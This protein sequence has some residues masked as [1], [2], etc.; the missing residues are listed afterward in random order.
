M[1]LNAP[2]RTHDF[3]SEYLQSPPTPGHSTLGYAPCATKKTLLFSLAFTERP[4]FLPTFTQWP[5]IFNKLL[6]TERPWHI[7]VTQRPLIFAFNDKFD[8]MLRN[9]SPFWPWKPLFFDAFQWKTHYFCAFCHWKTPFFDA[10]CHR[11]TPTSEVL[12]GTRTSLS[13]VSAPRAS[14]MLDCG[15]R[16]EYTRSSYHRVGHVV[17]GSY[18]I[19]NW[20]GMATFKDPTR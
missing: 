7:F 17:I 2:I 11:K 14:H 16:S 15:V 12:G 20:I 18:H 10:I 8:E 4:P 9:F 19:V 13:Y 5:P 6:V 1:R 3:Q